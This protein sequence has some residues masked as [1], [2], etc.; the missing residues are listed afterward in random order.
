[1]KQRTLGTQGLVF[2]ELGLGC[3]EMSE[4]YGTPD[5]TEAI[6]TIQDLN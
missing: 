3:M 1:M 4:F 2:S 6:A 5:K